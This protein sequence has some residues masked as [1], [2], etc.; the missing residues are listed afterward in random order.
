MLSEFSVL[1]IVNRIDRILEFFQIRIKRF[2]APIYTFAIFGLINYPAAFLVAYYYGASIYEFYFRASATLLCLILILKNLWPKSLRKFLPV[3]WYFTITFCLPILGTFLLLEHNTSQW[4]LMN[5]STGILILVLSLDT[6]MF[7]IS[8]TVGI[9]IGLLAF[10][11]A[12]GHINWT[13]SSSETIVAVYMIVAVY[14]LSGLFARSKEM[15]NAQMLLIKDKLNEKLEKQII[16]RNDNLNKALS[17][18]NVIINNIKEDM[19]APVEVIN[20]ISYK[21][22]KTWDDLNEDQRKDLAA[23]IDKNCVQLLSLVNHLSESKH[24]SGNAMFDM[25]VHN[26]EDIIKETIQDV[27]ILIKEKNIHIDFYKK[28]HIETRALFDKERIYDAI[29]DIIITAVKCSPID[30]NIR[31]DLCQKYT[32]LPSSVTING[33]C[34]EVK[35]YDVTP[36]TGTKFILG[37]LKQNTIN[38]YFKKIRRSALTTE[39]IVAAHSGMFWIE[40]DEKE[41]LSTSY[42]VLPYPNNR[43]SIDDSRTTN[44]KFHVLFVDDDEG[45]RIAGRMILENIGYTVKLFSSGTDLLDYLTHTDTKVDI[46]LLD[47]IMPDMEG[48]EVIKEL[49]KRKKYAKTPIIIQ[50]GIKCDLD[51]PG[52]VQY[53]PLGYISKPYNKKD[54]KKEIDS[55]L[56]PEKIS[57]NTNLVS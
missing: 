9:A 30:G 56:H 4:W 32:T 46:I 3:Y 6:L 51:F 14:V 40:T 10:I 1:V 26:I 22:A 37:K 23:D 47:M 39:E 49:R 20:H 36:K 42:F 21:L 55:Y 17:D 19:R 41:K 11:S 45:C 2:G 43:L 7:L 25:Q 16:K 57:D 38:N 27:H 34:V 24:T 8:L 13:A 15:Y 31:V 12:Y 29:K 5:C 50:T 53:T 54:L 28:K 48:L 33:L 52:L 44:S 18:Q 35:Y